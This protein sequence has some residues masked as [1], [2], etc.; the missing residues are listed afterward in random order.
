MEL[1]CLLS[2]EHR[3]F[4]AT[5]PT[6]RSPRWSRW[7]QTAGASTSFAQGKLAKSETSVVRNS[8]TFLTFSVT[9]SRRSL[10]PSVWASTSFAVSCNNFLDRHERAVLLLRVILFRF[11]PSRVAGEEGFTLLHQRERPVS[12]EHMENLNSEIF[13]SF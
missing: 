10:V 7:R 5:S 13:S 1:C 6:S 2:S 4:A 3:T 11:E 9:N 8:A 12:E